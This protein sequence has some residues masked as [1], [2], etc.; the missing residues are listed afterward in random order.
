ME[1]L[2]ELA[3]R[4]G[5]RLVLC[6]HSLGGAV[7]KL[8][9]LRLL[10]E[11]PDWPRPRVRCVAF[12]T[13]AVGNAALAELV[14]S[15]GWASHFTSY[16]LPEDQLVRLI[17]FAQAPRNRA[18]SSTGKPGA[19]STGS[20][21]PV[22]VGP[23]GSAPSVRAAAATPQGPSPAGALA[24]VP[25]PANPAVVGGEPL[26]QRAVSSLSVG[27]LPDRAF[28]TPGDSLSRHTSYASIT[29]LDSSASDC[30]PAGASWSDI[31]QLGLSRS[32]SFSAATSSPP[33][34]AGLAWGPDPA[35]LAAALAAARGSGD[36]SDCHEGR[37]VRGLG[38][39]GGIS[40]PAVTASALGGGVGSIGRRRFEVGTDTRDNESMD[41]ERAGA[42][43]EE[44]LLGGSPAAEVLPE[45]GACP[46]QTALAVAA[47]AAGHLGAE[48]A[49]AAIV[50]AA[51]A[52]RRSDLCAGRAGGSWGLRLALQR[53]RIMRHV[54]KVA[55]KARIPMPHAVS[56]HRRRLSEVQQQTGIA[57]QGTDCV[58]PRSR[59]AAGVL[60]L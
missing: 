18:S 16:Y 56:G 23:S 4:R 60:L 14:E 50:A 39:G 29:S 45:E 54:R 24:A 51:T 36:A 48:A 19:G 26:P 59:S 33:S 10:R 25:P 38:G 13:P 47:A 43:M 11:L 57:A 35:A 58:H 55:A 22:E 40:M 27:G 5:L 15:A 44:I 7:A 52:G 30:G 49:A 34:S 46:G 20:G 12:A 17:S 8:C 9:T 42:A 3:A 21:R 31:A 41:D 2:H 6:G 1:Q 28:Q 37:A 32:T 53:R